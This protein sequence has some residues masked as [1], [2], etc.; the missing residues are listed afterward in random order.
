MVEE[1]WDSGEPIDPD[2]FLE[3]YDWAEGLGAP[4]E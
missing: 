2:P 3:A 1:V 4:T